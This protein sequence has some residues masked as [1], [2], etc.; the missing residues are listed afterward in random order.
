[1]ALP[2]LVMPCARIGWTFGSY[3]SSNGGTKMRDPVVPCWCMSCVMIGLNALWTF[4]TASR[5]SICVN[6]N[7]SRL[8]S[9]PTY[10]W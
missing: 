7:Q 4:S 3:G 6:M 1:M 5:V 9:C 10:L 8:S 2:T